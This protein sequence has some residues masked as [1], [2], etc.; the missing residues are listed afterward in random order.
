V[1]VVYNTVSNVYSA[2]D[3]KNYVVVY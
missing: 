1:I 2:K 3:A